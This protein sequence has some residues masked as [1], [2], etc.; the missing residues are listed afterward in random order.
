MEV[1]ASVDS[2]RAPVQ[3]GL[4]PMMAGRK[5]GKERLAVRATEGVEVG[6]SVRFRREKARESRGLRAPDEIET[7]VLFLQDL[8]G[9]F[10]GQQGGGQG[11]DGKDNACPHCEQVLR[12][13]GTQWPFLFREVDL[14]SRYEVIGLAFGVATRSIG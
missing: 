3:A 6:A 14:F 9:G 5:L 7:T 4:V 13:R 1:V 10:R 12:I 8:N 2:G 11:P